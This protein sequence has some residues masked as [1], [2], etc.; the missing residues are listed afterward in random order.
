MGGKCPHRKIFLDESSRDDAVY[1]E[2][3]KGAAAA[4]GEAN[5]LPLDD[6]LPGMG[7]FYCLHCEYELTHLLTVFYSYAS[8]P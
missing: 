8:V 3:Q 2:L 7:Q 5:P 1:S 4:D 6:D